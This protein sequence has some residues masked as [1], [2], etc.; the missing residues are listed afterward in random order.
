MVMNPFGEVVRQLC[1]VLSARQSADLTDAELWQHYVHQRDEAAFAALVRRHGPM[2]MGVCRRILRNHQ[3]AEDAFQATFLVL[4]RRAGSVRT[5]GAISCWLHGVASRTAL[6]A[7]SA[8]ARR[9]AREASIPPRMAAPEDAWAELRFVLDEE[10]AQL[11][12]K[13]RAAVV[14]CDLE[15]KTR[16]E[17]AREL[18]C[19]EGTVA[20][21][22]ARGRRLLAERLA[23]RGYAASVIAAALASHTAIA[24][25]PA[26]ALVAQTT[27]AS[28]RAGH[29]ATIPVSAKVLA[30]TEGVMRTMFLT[31]LKIAITV[32]LVLGVASLGLISR[33][34]ATEPAGETTAPQDQ[35]PANAA[36]LRDRVA[37]MKAQLQRMEQQIAR[38][39]KET[40]GRGEARDSAAK[41]LAGRFKYK[42]EFETGWTESH[43]GGHI[44]ICEVWGTR[45]KIE[46][47]GQYLVRGKYRLPKGQRGKLY[48][49]VSDDG[50]W[51]REHRDSL[52]SKPWRSTSQRASSF[53]FTAW[54]ALGTS[55]STWQTGSAYSRTFANVYFGTGDTVW[56]KKP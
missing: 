9:R 53:S 42:V 39:E 7:R 48:F 14:L 54:R 24:C 20:S 34:A 2:V 30:L 47:G 22:L 50:T 19:A 29:G 13:Y 11:G 49:Y 52:I 12:K 8:A 26:P 44:E 4:V 37:R 51:G 6:E 43:D 1:G 18:G 56:R 15:G 45:P 38:L 32:V 33:T 40:G 25:M 55:T 36:N 31:K 10:I 28:S 27:A 35:P 17:A 46:V 21:R 5:P 23:R 16:Q 3:D 41:L